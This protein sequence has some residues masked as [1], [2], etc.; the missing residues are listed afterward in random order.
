M[1]IDKQAKQAARAY[2]SK[3]GISYIHARRLLTARPGGP[4]A[5]T[6]PPTGG[7]EDADWFD[8]YEPKSLYELIAGSLQGECDRLIGEPIHA[9]EVRGTDGIT[10][11]IDLPST[12]TGPS[13]HQFD[14]PDGSTDIQVDEEFEGGTV[15][16]DVT[17]RG[18]LTVEAL[19]AKGDAINAAEAGEAEIFEADFNRHY[20]S[21]IFEVEV[22]VA[23]EAILSPEYEGIENFRFAGAT[24]IGS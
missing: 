6:N 7:G 5:P 4:G 23:F 3:H 11:D 8:D 24:V 9:T 19:M 15:A 13:V 20:S 10:V 14:I 16:C 18:T 1:T 21:V 12:M 22:E 2:A 17:S